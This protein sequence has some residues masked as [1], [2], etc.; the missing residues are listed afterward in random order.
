MDFRCIAAFA[1]YV[2]LFSFGQ[3]PLVPGDHFAVAVPGAPFSADVVAVIES[4][5]PD[6]TVST[7]IAKD[8]IYRDSAGRTRSE[9]TVS[10]LVI[11]EDPV[12]G[13][14]ITLLVPSEMAYRRAFRNGNPPPQPGIFFVSEP[15]LTRK[16]GGSGEKSRKD[17]ALGKQTIDGVEFEG[18]RHTVTM[19]DEPSTVAINELWISRDLW[20]TGLLL[21]SNPTFKMTIKIQNLVRK[22]PDPALFTIPPDYSVQEL[23]LPLQPK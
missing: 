10:G 11:I 20:L 23:R 6:G 1:G 8:K 19:V 5:Q 7:S 21:R 4:T 13:I 17:E 3:A 14:M 2:A 18:S 16:S 15:D 22:E 9:S 12:A